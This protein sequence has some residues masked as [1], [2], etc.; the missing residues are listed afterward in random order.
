M[1]K[2]KMKSFDDLVGIGADSS[3]TVGTREI[4]ISDLKDFH[5][6]PF[7]V[8]TDEA[9]QE[10][11]DSIQK[12][13][14][15]VP[16]IVR[17]CPDGGYEVI[18]GHRRKQASILAGKKS[19]PAYVKDYDDDQAVLAMVDAN[20]QREYILPSE[21]ARAYAM[22]YEAMKH[23]GVRMEKHS[24]EEMGD[25]VG[26]SAK[27]V[28]RYICLA[29]LSDDLLERID[30]KE[31]GILQGVELSYLSSEHQKWLEDCLATKR[32]RINGVKAAKIREYASEEKLTRDTL[33][34][35]LTEGK[36]AKRKVVLKASKLQQF[37]PEEMTSEEIEEVLFDLMERWKAENSR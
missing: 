22:K 8:R 2:F 33:E 1:G 15:L 21:K 26:E 34:L 7:K 24:L 35:I 4:L 3:E 9:L 19:I 16:I 12:Q 25:S 32:V 30:R 17:P 31:I 5:K 6:H 20:L 27:T 36:P 10:L 18:S 13:G 23:Q 29:K 28:Q 11:T 14:V 37:F